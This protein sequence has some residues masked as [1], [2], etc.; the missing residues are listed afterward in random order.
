VTGSPTLKDVAAAAGVSLGTASNAFG[1]PDAV[2]DTTR[3]RVLEAARTLG[4]GGPD[5]TARCLR[6]GRTGTIG[7]IF[8]DRLPWAFSDPASALFLRGVAQEL[9]DRSAGLLIVPSGPSLDAA[10]RVVRESAV[11]GFVVYSVPDEDPRLQAAIQRRVPVVVV[12]EPVSA[13]GPFVGIDDRAGA[14]RAAAHVRALGHERLTVLSFPI[15]VD[16]GVYEVARE[17]LRGY[18]TVDAVHVCERNDVPTGRQVAAAALA[19]DPRPTAILAMSDALA[20]GA[21]LAAA[22]AGLEV[23]RD[24]SVVGF[25]DSPA[26]PLTTPPLTTIGQPTEEKG[27]LAV[28]RLASALDGRPAEART[29]L[30]TELVVRGSTGP[31]PSS[32][33]APRRESPARAG[34][35]RP[36]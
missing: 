16:A 32:P 31:A 24:L 1:R 30:P 17:R 26:A 3:E 22:D 6:T 13:P 33:P 25:D 29:V 20:A 34:G 19:A 2:A 36:R 12:D 9:E 21:L 35:R 28:A 8:T 14:A 18:G 23:P 10:T 27:R 7:L 15:E 5:P 4:Y 11:D